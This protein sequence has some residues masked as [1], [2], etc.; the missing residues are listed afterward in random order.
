MG[1]SDD[2]VEVRAR[3]WRRLAAL[4][5]LIEA[6]LER[7]L[8]ER[9]DLSVVEFTVLDALSR[10][11]GWHLR[12]AQLARA[13]GLSP[14]A[15]TRLVNRLEARGLIKRILCEDDRRGIYTEPT[16]AGRK[17]LRTAR[18][19]HDAVLDEALR[20]AG[21]TPELSDLARTVVELV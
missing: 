11:D 10:Q 3:G 19:T 8:Q 18:P 16:P 17:L 4:H 15:T 1:I 7:A 9:H 20:E 13:T 14:S 12:M 5:Q 2:A 21:D 6:R